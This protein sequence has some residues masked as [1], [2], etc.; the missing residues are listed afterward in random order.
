MYVFKKVLILYLAVFFAACCN[1]NV[2][3]TTI[4]GDGNI[5]RHESSFDGF[6][7]IVLNGIGNANI[8]FSNEFKVAVTTDRNIQEKITVNVIDNTMHLSQNSN[9]NFKPTRLEYDIYLPELRAINTRGSGNINID[10]GKSSQ[11]EINISGVGNVNAL[12][13]EVENIYIILSGV[14]NA[15][16]WANSSL[17]GNLSGVGDILF[18]GNPTN[19]I[20]VSGIGN[21]RPI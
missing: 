19:N 21:I 14:G 17:N 18:K 12:N 8:H 6:D 20:R 7:S 1:L 10:T 2:V 4:Q 9:L 3:D 5:T 16:I 13:Y 15:R 11:L